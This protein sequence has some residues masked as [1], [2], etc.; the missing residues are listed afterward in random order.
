MKK[1]IVFSC[2]ALLFAVSA[3]NGLASG[4][5]SGFIG[6]LV[7]AAHFAF[8]AFRSF[9]SGCADNEK[10]VSAMP[11]KS[12]TPPRKIQYFCGF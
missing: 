1:K 5:T 9:K 12:S 3:V 4:N 11:L 7:I 10:S 2:L 6:C 8:L